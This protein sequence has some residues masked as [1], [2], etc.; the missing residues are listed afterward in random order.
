MHTRTIRA[1]KPEVPD[2]NK[3]YC[4]DCDA[5]A[6]KWAA[7]GFVRMTI[8]SR[9]VARW[10]VAAWV[11]AA[12]MAA[13][14]SLSVLRIPIQVTDSLIPLLQVQAAPSAAAVFRSYLGRTGFLRPVNWSQIKLLLDVSGGNYF[15]RFAV[16][17]CSSSFCSS[18][19]SR[20][21]PA[22]AR[23]RSS[24]RLPLPSRC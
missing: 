21:R 18:C 11:A 5:A 3:P 7:H 14:V 9:A 4:E 15:S 13:A 8:G 12:I 1:G 23:A 6:Q 20:S 17:T 24:S 22:F 10:G 2:F 16:S 19:S